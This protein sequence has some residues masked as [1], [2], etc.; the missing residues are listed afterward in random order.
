MLRV[1]FPHSFTISEHTQVKVI[2]ISKPTAELHVNVADEKAHRVWTANN[3][4]LCTNGYKN[5]TL[6][7]K[8]ATLEEWFGSSRYGV[9]GYM[10]GAFT[11]LSVKS[12]CI[13]YFPLIGE[14]L[15]SANDGD[16]YYYMT[17]RKFGDRG[18]V[19]VG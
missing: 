2:D 5:F 11:D 19:S 9:V 15:L 6:R 18:L 13:S 8:S 1:R 17:V 3:I 12:G 4:I 14:S 16:V 10:I 7:S